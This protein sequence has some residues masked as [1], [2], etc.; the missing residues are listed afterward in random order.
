MKA[1]LDSIVSVINAVPVILE[2]GNG[3]PSA[4]QA[5]L[6]TAV[7]GKTTGSFSGVINERVKHG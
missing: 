3:N 5:A 4:L 7:T 2:P 6:K 1:L